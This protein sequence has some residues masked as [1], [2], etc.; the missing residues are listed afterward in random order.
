MVPIFNWGG[1]F[2][3]MLLHSDGAHRRPVTVLCMLYKIR[4]NP[5][6]P[7]YN[8]LN[9]PFVPVRV[10]SHSALVV[11]RYIYLCA[12]LLWNLTV[13]QDFYSPLSICVTIL[14]TLYSLL[15]HWRVSRAG[16]MLFYWAKPLSFFTISLSLLSFYRLVVWGWCLCTDKGENLP[17]PCIATLFK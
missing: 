7:L 9:V 11:H 6:H 17:H 2:T 12:S 8:A 14:P 1:C 4:C 10:T 13:L 5:M 15:W 3:V 16:P